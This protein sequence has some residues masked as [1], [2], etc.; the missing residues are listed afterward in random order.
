MA[1]F[2][3]PLSDQEVPLT[4]RHF[5]MCVLFAVLY[6]SQVMASEVEVERQR[7]AILSNSVPAVPTAPALL[8]RLQA[9]NL[10]LIPDDVAVRGLI[11]GMYRQFREACPRLPNEPDGL[12]G[13]VFPGY[14]G[15]G[16]NWQVQPLLEGYRDAEALIRINGCDAKT[17]EGVRRGINV[18]MHDR[19]RDPPI[20]Q[21]PLTATLLS[22][23]A[24]ERLHVPAFAPKAVTSTKL[25]VCWQSPSSAT[26]HEREALHQLVRRRLVPVIASGQSS[27]ARAALKHGLYPVYYVESP[28]SY[29]LLTYLEGRQSERDQN[30]RWV[31]FQREDVSM[32]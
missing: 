25:V 26:D 2:A 32:H 15:L 18:V 22:H 6:A 9:G 29:R 13:T 11:L 23:E 16:T 17:V 21:S 5:R 3:L 20:N 27:L 14:L 24:R 30:C 28:S 7:A 31:G 19:M 12:D 8:A 1:I 10:A 4:Q